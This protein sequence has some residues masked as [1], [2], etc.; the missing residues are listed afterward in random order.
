MRVQPI[1][2]VLVGVVIGCTGGV[3][4]AIANGSDP[5]PDD[6]RFDAVCAFSHTAWLRVG[7]GEDPDQ[8]HNWFGAATLIAA[9]AI[10]TAKHLLSGHGRLPQPG[11][12]SVRFRR[13]TDGR[14]GNI[15]AG[16]D[17]FYHAKVVRW[18]TAP[19]ADLAVG[20]L[21]HAVNHIDPIPVDLR[22][23]ALAEHRGMLAGW[24]SESRWLGVA[25]PRRRL[26]IGENRL[27]C[28]KSQKLVLI[29]DLASELRNW[30]QGKP[31]GRWHQRQFIVTDAAVP[32]RH[33][34]GGAM[35]VED[36][37]GA[38]RL[39]GV[40]SSSQTGAWL[41]ACQGR[42]GLPIPTMAAQPPH[43]TTRP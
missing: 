15:E 40:I 35:L 34:S 4:I 13:R 17:S 23:N 38:L 24:G 2:L 43:P 3:A 41:A 7:G 12:F 10:L 25:T 11:A 31:S 1:A 22:P 16:P 21:D 26:R 28:L 33:D 29:T 32:N 14:L 42:G 30:K 18:E 36:E 9:D 39:I 37:H 20:F 5:S 19:E 6:R 27:T 8:E